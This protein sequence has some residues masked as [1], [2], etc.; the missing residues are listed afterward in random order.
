MASRR[1][2]A[3]QGTTATTSKGKSTAARNAEPIDAHPPHL[4]V[5]IEDVG[6]EHSFPVTASEAGI[7][8]HEIRL[9]TEGQ[10]L[11]MLASLQR[12]LNKQWAEA[13][14]ECEK[15]VL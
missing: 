10:L 14:R 8:G 12:Q 5:H 15:D 6:G 1:K 4:D 7:N 3:S 9:L 13:A 11:Q 2:S